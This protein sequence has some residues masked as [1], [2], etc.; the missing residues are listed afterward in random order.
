MVL[1]LPIA[2][3]RSELGSNKERVEGRTGEYALGRKSCRNLFG[4]DCPCKDCA[5]GFL[6][7][8]DVAEFGEVN[9]NALD[10]DGGPWR[11]APGSRYKWY[12][13]LSCPFHLEAH[14]VSEMP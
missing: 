12:F 14:L 13:M 5:F 3:A 7:Y 2:V 10:A 11:I 4:E 6:V 8:F 1:P 9:D